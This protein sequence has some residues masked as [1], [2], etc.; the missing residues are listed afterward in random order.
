MSELVRHEILI[1]DRNGQPVPGAYVVITNGPEPV[2]EIALVTDEGGRFAVA[3]PP[4][5]WTVQAHGEA[6]VGEADIDLP[7]TGPLAIAI[8]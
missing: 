8:D 4:G 3:L 6:G 2:P 7:G 1:V 5:R